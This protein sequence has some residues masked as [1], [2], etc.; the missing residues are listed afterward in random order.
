[1]TL[2]PAIGLATIG[3]AGWDRVFADAQWP[4]TL[5]ETRHTLESPAAVK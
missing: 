5:I 1:M 2:L 3:V 4:V